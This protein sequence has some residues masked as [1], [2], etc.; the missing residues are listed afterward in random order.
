MED[1]TLHARRKIN[2]LNPHLFSV[3]FVS[4]DDA[5]VHQ[6]PYQRH[7]RARI[8][9]VRMQCQAGI[10]TKR[11]IHRT[12]MTERINQTRIIR[13]GRLSS[14]GLPP[15]RQQRKQPG[16]GQGRPP[17]PWTRPGRWS[18]CPLLAQPVFYSRF[19]DE[20][21]GEFV[22]GCLYLSQVRFER[23][24][25]ANTWLVCSGLVLCAWWHK[26]IL[27]RRERANS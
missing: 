21:G 24:D 20:S 19:A 7:C 2:K 11:S 8:A 23:I 17:R 22:E 6:N 1:N 25:R 13:Y 4:G 26:A 16:P 18:R 3:H 12:D 14:F 9:T 27:D 10:L 15:W 5:L